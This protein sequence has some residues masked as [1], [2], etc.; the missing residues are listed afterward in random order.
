M[1]SELGWRSPKAVESDSDAFES[2]AAVSTIIVSSFSF[3]KSETNLD[4]K[5]A[6]KEAQAKA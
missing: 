3:H 5:E 1:Q 2:R 4:L 6:R